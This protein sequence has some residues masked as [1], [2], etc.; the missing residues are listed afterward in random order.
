MAS[1]IPVIGGNRDGSVDPLCANGFSVAIEPDNEHSLVSAIQALL[2][3]QP[4]DSIVRSRFKLSFF[5]DQVCALVELI[6]CDFK[7]PLLG[8]WSDLTSRF[9]A[10]EHGCL[11]ESV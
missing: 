8:R 7:R 3:K 6:D 9:D 1:G 4:G 11:E 5:T 10:H 2:D